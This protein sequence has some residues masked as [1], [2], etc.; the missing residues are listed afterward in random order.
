MRKITILGLNFTKQTRDTQWD[1]SMSNFNNISQ[2]SRVENLYTNFYEFFWKRGRRRRKKGGR[3]TVQFIRGAFKI[4]MSSLWKFLRRGSIL[5][6]I[7]K[8]FRRVEIR[9]NEV[10]GEKKK[11]KKRIYFR[12]FLFVCSR[13]LR[14]FQRWLTIIFEG[15]ILSPVWNEI[16]HRLR[17][18]NLP[19]HDSHFTSNIYPRWWSLA[20]QWTV[21]KM[22]LFYWKLNWMCRDLFILLLF[23]T[24]CRDGC[25][26][27]RG[28][29]LYDVKN[30]FGTIEV[31]INEGKWKF[32]FQNVY[33][34]VKWMIVSWKRNCWMNR[35]F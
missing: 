31:R 28:E 26:A 25:S 22:H 13:E 9:R 10:D 21:W 14:T 17:A 27:V 29:L 20:R 19:Y 2:H 23:A 8:I 30:I 35:N 12:G 18:G 15:W 5:L 32:C 4:Q 3:H 1:I 33:L 34:F 7:A 24:V 6:R 16:S 11:K